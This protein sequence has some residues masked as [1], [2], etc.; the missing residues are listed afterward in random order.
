MRTVKGQAKE[1]A[2]ALFLQI[3]LQKKSLSTF[4]GKGVGP[5]ELA[6]VQNLASESSYD[7]KSETQRKLYVIWIE[8][9]KLKTHPTLL[10][11]GWTGFNITVR[12]NTGSNSKH[13]R[14]PGYT[15][16]TRH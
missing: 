16:F 9:R 15:R 11:P 6:N 12:R 14:I 3:L 1:N 8:I 13:H 5:G 10:V 4:R 2:N 7:D